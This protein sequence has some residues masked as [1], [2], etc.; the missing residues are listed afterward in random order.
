MKYSTL[1][2]RFVVHFPD[3]LEPGVLYISIEFKS[4]SHLCCCGCGEEVVTPLSPA[5]WRIIYDGE[6]VSLNPSVGSWTLACR[7]HYV[8]TRGQ[9]RVAGQ[10]TDEQIAAGR[11]R[12]R[13]ATERQFGNAVQQPASRES[14]NQVVEKPRSWFARFGSWIFGG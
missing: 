9:V 7:S 5:D 8:I 13:L 2:H 12:D 14:N 6:S 10:W 11:R 3:E 1:K 4:V